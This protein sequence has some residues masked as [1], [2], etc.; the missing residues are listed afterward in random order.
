[1]DAGESVACEREAV[2]AH[3]KAGHSVAAPD[4]SKHCARTVAESVPA[5][6][7]GWLEPSA[8]KNES[9]QVCATALQRTVA[10]P[11]LSVS[12]DSNIAL[13]ASALAASAFGPGDWQT[14]C[15]S[16]WLEPPAG[17]AGIVMSRC[18]TG[19][20]VAR[21]I[22]CCVAP[23]EPALVVLIVAVKVSP[24]KRLIG[25]ETLAT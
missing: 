4:A 12:E 16:C 20:N 19:G 11:E 18:C 8:L 13:L 6:E 1:M 25:A 9:E 3:E 24:A 22:D 15:A 21:V 2:F 10:E 23:A 14:N 5:N 7:F 17:S